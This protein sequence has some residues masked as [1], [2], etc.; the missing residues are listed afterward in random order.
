MKKI[1]ERKKV[2]FICTHNSARSQMA[3]AFL[4]S[5]YGERFVGYSAGTKPSK[6]N[7][8]AVKAMAEVGIDIS[9]NRSKNIKEF[10]GKEFHYAITLCDSAKNECQFFPGA[11]KLIHAGF[12]NPSTFV[13]TDGEIML[14]F[15]KVRDDIADWIKKF[16]EEK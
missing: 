1:K 12:V 7:P 13:G 9:K 2:L 11:K 6:I 16:A 14:G 15:R 10:L 8:Y 3:E 5:G 4:N